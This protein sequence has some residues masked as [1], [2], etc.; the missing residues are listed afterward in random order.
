MSHF[1]DIFGSD[2]SSESPELQRPKSLV[3][4]ATPESPPLTQ[5]PHRAKHLHKGHQSPHKSTHRTPHKSS[6]KSSHITPHKDNH[7]SAHR[8]T[9]RTPHKSSHKASHRHGHALNPSRRP[10]FNNHVNEIV[11]YL[12][13]LDLKRDCPKERSL[14]SMEFIRC[15]VRHYNRKHKEAIRI[16]PHAN[17]DMHYEKFNQVVKKY[18]AWH[19][20]SGRR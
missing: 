8:T 2:A 12:K 13:K 15:G 6:H 5:I 1:R 9:H 4:V 3:R 18:R 10:T 17:D 7:K 19:D 11:D 20:Q 14:Y 16:N